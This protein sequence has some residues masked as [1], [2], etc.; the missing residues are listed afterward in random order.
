M[1]RA[2]A[3]SSVFLTRVSSLLLVSCLAV[4]GVAWSQDS[5]VS[6][7]LERT[8]TATPQEKLQFAADAVEEQKALVKQ[9]QKTLDDAKR[10]GDDDAVQCINER[11]AQI[12]ALAQVTELAKVAM[13]QAVEAGQTERADHELRKIAVALGKTR[14]LSNEAQ[15][16]VQDAD[17]ASGETSVRV[18]GALTTEDNETLPL[19]VDPMD[20]GI[21]PPQQSP[22]N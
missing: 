1:K 21:D 3:G 12:R 18:E 19:I 7:D 9:T 5:G 17:V 16:C 20:F 14:Q 4:G 22:F 13:A 6:G 2:I 10:Q 11:L 8:A 15:G